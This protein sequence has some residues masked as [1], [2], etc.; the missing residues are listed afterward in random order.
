MKRSLRSTSNILRAAL[1]ALALVA[2]S[3]ISVPSQAYAADSGSQEMY[4]LYNPYSGEHFYT[5][6]TGE[7]DHLKSVG[8]RYEGVGWIAPKSSS[9]PVYRLY[10]RYAGDHHYTTSASERNMLVSV[11]W[12]YEG[13]GW[14]SSDARTTPVYRQYNPYARTGTHN[15]T[16]SK[17]END[18]LA[19]IGWRAEGIGWYGIST[20]STSSGTPIMGSSQA[21]QAQMVNLYKKMGKTY[22]YS[23]NSEAPNIEKFVSILCTQASSEGVRADVVFAQAML[24]TGWLQFGGDV[25]KEQYNFAGLGATGGG[26]SGNSFSSISEGLL[27]QV[28]HLK[29]YASTD[30]LNNPCVDQRFR[31]VTRGCATTVEALSGKWATGS[32]YGESIKKILNQL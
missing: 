25:K 8:W 16:T 30:D 31:Y 26:V 6:S 27:A 15:Y 17:G 4:R 12:T 28:Q 9:T 19:S 3:L 22:P 1:V 13:I 14:Y 29:A 23:S 7:R 5:A 18:Y 24:E 21:S 11:G 32:G 2:T 10:N 20:S